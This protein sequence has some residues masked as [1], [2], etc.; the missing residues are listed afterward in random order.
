M[1]SVTL[2]TTQFSGLAVEGTKLFLAGEE[3][4]SFVSRDSGGV[5]KSFYFEEESVLQ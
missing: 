5:Y 1:D 4:A 2:E 3:H